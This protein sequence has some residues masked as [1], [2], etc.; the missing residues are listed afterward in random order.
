MLLPQS[1]NTNYTQGP[2]TRTRDPKFLE[3]SKLLNLEA[4]IYKIGNDV[5]SKFDLKNNSMKVYTL[6]NKKVQNKCFRQL[7]LYRQNSNATKLTLDEIQAGTQPKALPGLEKEFE[8]AQNN[9]LSCQ[10]DVFNFIQLFTVNSTI[11]SSF[12]NTSMELCFDECD[13]GFRKNKLDED[14]GKQCLNTC[15]K[16]FKNNSYS[17][18]NIMTSESRQIAKIIDKL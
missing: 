11:L 10:E 8:R 12:I 3:L 13:Q 1:M 6:G 14:G 9:L 7:E 16:L 2:L 17:Y 15:M 4:L 5:E 18:G